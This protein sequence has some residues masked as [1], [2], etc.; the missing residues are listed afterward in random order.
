MSISFFHK[1][2]FRVFTT[3][4]PACAEVVTALCY[5]KGIF[6]LFAAD[7]LL[8]RMGKALRIHTFELFP[9]H[10]I[11]ILHL[12]KL[13]IPIKFIFYHFSLPFCLNVFLS[14]V[15]SAFLWRYSI[16]Y[17]TFCLCAIC[18]CIQI[19]FDLSNCELV[20]LQNIWES[21]NCIFLNRNENA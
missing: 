10:I 2:F 19:F 15:N 17:K 20:P 8:A 11:E 21:R 7:F 3:H 12:V 14:C 4:S 18:V 6:T 13:D 9:N 5:N 1:A 16:P